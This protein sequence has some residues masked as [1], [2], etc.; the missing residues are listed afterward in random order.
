MNKFFIYII[1]FLLSFLIQFAL[2]P[3]IAIAGAS[4]LVLLVP[5][6]LVSIHSGPAFGSLSGFICGLIYDF[7]YGSVIGCMALT[8]TLL[9]AIVAFIASNINVRTLSVTAVLSLFASVFCELVYGL[10]MVLTNADVA[11]LATTLISHS[12]P[13]AIYDTVILFFFLFI[14]HLVMEDDGNNPTSQIGSNDM[15]STMQF[16]K[17]SS[18]NSSRLKY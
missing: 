16:V 7:V 6:V 4:P 14:I 9:A 1:T 10:S 2:A 5:V 11:G 17:K 3:A 8:L 18:H 15:Q 13:C 12:L